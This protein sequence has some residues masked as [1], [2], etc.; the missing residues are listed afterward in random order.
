MSKLRRFEDNYECGGLEFPIALDEI[1]I[2]S[3][4][5]LAIELGKE[6]L[7]ILRKAKFDNQRRTANLLPID[8]G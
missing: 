3:I 1:D 5:I 8:Q 4:N 6:K 7:Y 2:F